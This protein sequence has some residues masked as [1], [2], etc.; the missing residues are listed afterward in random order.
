MNEEKLVF[1]EYERITTKGILL[2]IK[3]KRYTYNFT[4]KKLSF[5]I[6]TPKKQIKVLIDDF[7]DEKYFDSLRLINGDK[8]KINNVKVL[9]A[10]NE[11]GK[12]KLI[13]LSFDELSSIQVLKY[14]DNEKTFR[15]LIKARK[16]S[17]KKIYENFKDNK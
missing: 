1:E 14:V 3:D 15:E 11:M 6:S 9:K 13:M 12:E 5:I 7:D 2:N 17:V 16:M 4:Y 8:V 10:R